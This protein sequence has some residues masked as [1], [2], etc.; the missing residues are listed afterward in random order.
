VIEENEEEANGPDVPQAQDI[1]GKIL[2]ILQSE[3]IRRP[4]EETALA[5]ADRPTRLKRAV[6]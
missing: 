4:Y 3:Y 6:L 5:A 2:G 1:L